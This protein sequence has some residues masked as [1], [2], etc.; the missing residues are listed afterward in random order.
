[1]YK[2]KNYFETK[3]KTT[4]RK[5]DIVPDEIAKD[6]LTNVIKEEGELLVETPTEVQVITEETEVSEKPK[7]KNKKKK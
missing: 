4:Y 7:K 5:G 1:M 6:Y 3:Y 2:A